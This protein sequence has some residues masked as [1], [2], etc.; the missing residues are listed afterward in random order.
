[1]NTLI[2]ILVNTL[3]LEVVID[4]FFFPFAFSHCASRIWLLTTLMP[5]S[6][7]NPGTGDDYRP[8]GGASCISKPWG[9]PLDI[10]LRISFPA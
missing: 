2:S 7:D 4:C 9:E 5:T 8:G 3:T 1:M 6:M 10:R